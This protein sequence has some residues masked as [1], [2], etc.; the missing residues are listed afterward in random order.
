MTQIVA[1]RNFG[2]NFSTSPDGTIIYVAGN[3]GRLRVYN[4]A[5]GQLLQNWA[6]GNDLEGIT[7]SRD[8]AFAI[9]TEAVPATQGQALYRVNLQNGN[10][11]SYHYIDNGFGYSLGDVAF[12]DNNTVIISQRIIPGYSGW[13]SM[14]SLDLNSGTFSRHGSYYS[15]G[16]FVA[17]LSQASTPGNVLVGQLGLSS[18][19]YLFLSSSGNAVS[20]NGVYNNGVFGLAQGVEA[21][22]GTGASGRVAIST[23]GSLHLYNGNFSYL[24]N[25]TQYFPDLGYVSGLVFSQDASILY[26]IDGA[27]DRIIGIS[28]TDFFQ[29]ANI[30]LGDNN[31]PILGIGEELILS[32]NSAYFLVATDS[33]VLNVG[34]PTV[35]NRTDGDDVI[36]GTA[37]VDRLSGGLGNDTLSGYA[38]NDLINGGGGNDIIDGGEGQNILIGGAGNDRLIVGSEADGTEIKGGDDFDTLVVTGAVALGG[39]PSGIEAIEMVGG[40][41]TLSGMQFSNGFSPLTSVSGSGSITVNMDADTPF[42]PTNVS[43]V[44]NGVTVTV[45]GT[46]GADVVKLGGGLY[47]V[48]AGDGADQ[49]RGGRDADSI[50]GGNGND[51]ILGFTG[52]DILTGGA[53]SDQFRYLFSG[54][55]GLGAAADR[56]TDFVIGTDRLNFAQLDTDAVTPGVQ[57]FAFIGNGAFGATG[58]AQIRYTNSGADLL[59]QADING[60]G[61]ADMEIVLQ[62][63]NGGT[64]T[65]ADFIL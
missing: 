16:P 58:A 52:A 34:Y 43:F 25:L 63:L 10:V 51:K 18:A 53:G 39:A 49:V 24:T 9:I 45:N 46:S 13:T 59:V 32:A 17:S 14:I 37:G 50:N 31:Y 8:G 36:V 1:T 23:G 60:D 6:V 62:G 20:G 3:D 42:A 5:T 56:I 26:A 2:E 30:P 21:F 15:G 47:E 54:D 57:G 35:G 44:G 19:E 7:I 4:A 28:L 38:G 41:L 65:G 22:G 12:S 40:S 29:V 11:Q 64:L 55:S 33:G 27:N 48:F 61:I